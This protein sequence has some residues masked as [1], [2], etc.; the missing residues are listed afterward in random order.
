MLFKRSLL[1]FGLLAVIIFMFPGCSDNPNQAPL[2]NS[3]LELAPGA[4]WVYDATT[5]EPMTKTAGYSDQETWTILPATTYNGKQVFPL[6]MERTDR[7]AVNYW[8]LN[9]SGD[10]LRNYGQA[11]DDGE[12]VDEWGYDSY[13]L[14]LSHNLEVGMQWSCPYNVF[15]LEGTSGDPFDVV[16]NYEV[17]AIESVSV[18]AGDFENA[19]KVERTQIIDPSYSRKK[20]FWFVNGIGM[21]K[22]EEW[23]V[24]SAGSFM[25][26]ELDLSTYGVGVDM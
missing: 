24:Y 7:N 15:P 4:Y 2:D 26:R 22:Q 12:T 1:F 11:S 9:W 18:P 13:D 19:V 17:T 10:G 3:F 20:I 25:E 14:L 6:Q 23:Q 5:I 8:Y 16:Y 21:V